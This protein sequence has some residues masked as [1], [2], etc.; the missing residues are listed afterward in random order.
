MNYYKER[1]G[2]LLLL[3]LFSMNSLFAQ[4]VLKVVSPDTK[5]VFE[6]RVERGN[7][8]QYRL[9]MRGDKILDWSSLGLKTDKSTLGSKLHLKSLGTTNVRKTIPWIFG[10]SDS[11]VDHYNEKLFKISEGDLSYLLQVRLYNRT[12]AFRY[13]QAEVGGI[14]KIKSELTRFNFPQAYTIYQY[15]QESTF[16]PIL[17]DT[18][19]K[20]CDLPATLISEKYFVSI[21]E[22]ANDFYTKVELKGIYKQHALKIAFMRDSVVEIV[23]ERLTPWRTLSVADDAIGLHEFS[24]LNYR[25][26]PPFSRM[27]DVKPGKLI[28]SALNTDAT[29]ACINFAEKHHY[30]YVMFDAGWYGAEFR[31]TS[32]PTQVISSIDMPNVIRYGKEHGIGIILYVNYVGLKAKLDTLLPLYKQ[33]G[34]AGFKF[35][36]VDGLTQKG[37]LWLRQAIKKVNDY[38]FI[39]NIHDNYKPTGLS[40]TYPAL[41]TQEGIRGDENSPDAFHN[42]ALPFTRFI[43]GAGDFTF[44]FP[45]SKN[46]F[47]KNIRV[48]KAQQLA[49]SVVYYSPLQSMLWYGKAEDYTNDAEIEFYDMVPTTWNESI[50]LAGSIGRNIC[51]ARRNGNDWYLGAIAGL[52]D[53]NSKI[54]TDFLTP[55]KR[56]TATV[57]EDTPIKGI[58]KRTFKIKKGDLLPIVL[59]AK[60]GQAMI[61]R[62]DN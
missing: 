41:L 45:N 43:A 7:L 47:S 24:S 6:I 29:I 11:I 51:V 8:V 55:G 52:E 60:S 54:E 27:P 20:T 59:N 38:G 3:I 14:R 40:H 39:L 36:F 21:G 57:Y 22:A 13:L 62:M 25:L 34:I 1:T 37:L 49:L 4:N 12:L 35:G 46:S 48:S 53:W 16:T 30:Q 26:S 2:I 17:I 18:L 50:Y 28:R 33:W 5:T 61:I 31:S 32:D 9:L 10:E 42:T 58:N 23:D 44:C 15:N 19:A 56:Y